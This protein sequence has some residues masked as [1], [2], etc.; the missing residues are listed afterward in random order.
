MKREILV[1]WLAVV[2]LL[3]VIWAPIV[4]SIKNAFDS[5]SEHIESDVRLLAIL[6]GRFASR[7]T[8]VWTFK[9]EHLEND[10]FGILH[11]EHQLSVIDHEGK[12]IFELGK[13]IAENALERTSPLF[14]SGKIIGEVRLRHSINE[15]IAN[16]RWRGLLGII[17]SISLL[18]VFH[19][20]V[21][22]PQKEARKRLRE[23]AL[24]LELATRVAGIGVWD[25]DLVGNILVWDARMHEICGLPPEQFDGTF[26]AFLA[27]IHPDDKSTVQEKAGHAIRSGEPTNW[28]FRILRPDGALRILEGHGQCQFDSHGNPLRMTGVNID[29]TDRKS[30]ER[31][32][33]EHRDNLQQI[34]DRQVAVVVR[35]KQEAEQANLAKSEFLTNMSHELRTP[36]HAV[37]SFTKLALGKRELP[38]AKAIEYFT[39]IRNS[40]ER[41]L[42]LINDLLDL[43]KM[44][45]GRMVLN[46]T[47]NE[48]PTIIDKVCSEISQV[49]AERQIDFVVTSRAQE[50]SLW[51]DESKIAQ[52]LRNLLANAIRFSPAQGKISITVDDDVIS[53]GRRVNDSKQ[54]PALR[55]VVSDQGPGIPDGEIES[56]FEKF[57][58]SSAS[59]TGAGGTGLGLPICREI[60]HLH[61]GS[62]TAGNHTGGGAF[63]SVLLPRQ[64]NLN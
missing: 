22:R 37:L 43:S 28:E 1:R 64:S 26:S 25:L 31:D 49:A 20:Y 46:S 59:K 53:L 52:L 12:S 16:A 14:Q 5:T 32:L 56:I 35:A 63:F 6:I 2:A 57:V 34:V 13:P 27:L 38:P 7:N 19:H 61:R 15:I 41:L 58:Q 9:S 39:H 4:F 3:L 24:R 30:N 54:R 55:I 23:S 29:I 51:C 42:C 10:L 40:G 33:A 62:V 17:L 44:E 60:A 21:I 47:V 8:E 18:W 48:L 50:P 11:P 45:A 36:L